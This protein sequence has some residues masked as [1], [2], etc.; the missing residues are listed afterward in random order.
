MKSRKRI[1]IVNQKVEGERKLLFRTRIPG[2][3]GMPARGPEM[4]CG[5]MDAFHHWQSRM[6]PACRKTWSDWDQAGIRASSRT[7]TR[8]PLDRDGGV[9]QIVYKPC[10]ARHSASPPNINTKNK[11]TMAM[12]TYTDAMDS[13]ASSPLGTD[14]SSWS[15]ST[16]PTTPASSPLFGP[17]KGDDLT[18]SHYLHSSLDSD[19]VA[20]SGPV[21]NV[22]VVGAGY[23]GRLAWVSARKGSCGSLT[24]GNNEQGDQQQPS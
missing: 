23:V 2:Y 20:A 5:C 15:P 11:Q 3:G 24:T 6:Q 16:G 13:I 14:E 22:C 17:A 19:I 7:I 12:A 8:L 9:Q 21:R 1:V 10:R 18:L 4:R